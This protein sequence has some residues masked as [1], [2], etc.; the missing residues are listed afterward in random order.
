MKKTNFRPLGRDHLEELFDKDLTFGEKVAD[1]VAE[2]VGSWQFIIIF[3]VILLLW[4]G[5]N[6]AALFFHIP[7]FLFDKPPF[8]LLN[9]MLSFVAAF[10]APMIM[11]SQ[12][13]TAEKDRARD[14]LQFDITTDM[15][16]EI[17]ALNEKLN[18]L[19]EGQQEVIEEI[20]EAVEEIIEEHNTF[21]EEY[22]DDGEE[23]DEKDS[24]E[25]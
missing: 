12:N 23:E 8:I 9:L 22:A 25:D 13:R 24:E 14:E 20:H 21:I 16:A 2:F 6:V 1:Q 3:S 19:L 10:Q 18:V 15:R 17:Y 5:I 11:M 4:M 7:L